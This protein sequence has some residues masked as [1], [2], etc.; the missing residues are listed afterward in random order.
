[1]CLKGE[2][3]TSSSNNFWK[4]RAWK[5]HGVKQNSVLYHSTKVIKLIFRNIYAVLNSAYWNSI[6]LFERL[7][8]TSPSI[9]FLLHLQKFF[10]HKKGR[11]SHG[12]LLKANIKNLFSMTFF[13]L[14]KDHRDAYHSWLLLNDTSLVFVVGLTSYVRQIWKHEN[15]QCSCSHGRKN[16][17]DF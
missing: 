16:L 3:F 8:L 6:L 13:N 7:V 4:K 1:M 11:N 5:S 17:T 2:L 9:Y 14:Q 10:V 12:S 15:G